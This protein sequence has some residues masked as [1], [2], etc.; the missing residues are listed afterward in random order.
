MLEALEKILSLVNTFKDAIVALVAGSIGFFGSFLLLKKQL[1]ENRKERI[2]DRKIDAAK[3]AIDSISELLSFISKF[4]ELNQEVR[5]ITNGKTDFVTSLK[6]R[7]YWEA[8]KKEEPEIIDEVYNY[9]HLMAETWKAYGYLGLSSHPELSKKFKEFTE[10]VQTLIT[11][12]VRA[13]WDEMLG[14]GNVLI[15]DFKK[16]IDSTF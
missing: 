13:K 14:K 11:E 5:R 8:L 7:K 9:Y 10:Y 4:S 6:D 12:D 1:D 3:K 15:D 2:K 16:E